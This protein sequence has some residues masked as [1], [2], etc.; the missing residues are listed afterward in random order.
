MNYNPKPNDTSDIQLSPELIELTEKIAK[1]VHYVF[2]MG[3][4]A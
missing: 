3:R 1:N 4:I 2:V